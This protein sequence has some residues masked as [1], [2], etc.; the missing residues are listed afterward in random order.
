MGRLIKMGLFGLGK[1]KAKTEPSTAQAP[2]E[3][4]IPDLQSD[5]SSNSLSELPDFPEQMP[6]ET[7][8]FDDIDSM[9][10]NDPF[11]YGNPS[12][13]EVKKEK[14]ETDEHLADEFFENLDNTPKSEE[15][16]QPFNPLAEKEE[17]EENP[18]NLITKKEERPQEKMTETKPIENEHPFM[19]IESAPI[20]PEI[21]P[22]RKPVVKIVG[23]DH[24]LDSQTFV[25][26]TTL[27]YELQIKARKMKNMFHWSDLTEKEAKLLDTLEDA[28]E[29][30]QKKL[31]NT[32]SLLTQR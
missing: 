11:S 27:L 24:Y 22:T 1:K 17:P 12:Q 10:N 14:K 18:F 30:A 9:N 15:M 19:P 25:D 7:Q 28:A 5:F 6:E 2:S 8:Q 26:A 20:M 31:V 13:T 21:K 4:A 23:E 29:T 16:E 3:T 32:D